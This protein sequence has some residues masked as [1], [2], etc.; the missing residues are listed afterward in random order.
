MARGTMSNEKQESQT[1]DPEIP[2]GK[3]ASIIYHYCSTEAFASIV[4][5]KQLWLSNSYA[6]S[7]YSENTWIVPQLRNKLAELR[8]GTTAAYLDEMAQ[9]YDLNNVAPYIASFSANGD[10]LSQW[11]A[12]SNDGTGVA[13]GFNSAAFNVKFRLPMPAAILDLCIGLAPVLY[14]IEQQKAQVT[15]AIEQNLQLY[16]NKQV[17]QANAMIASVSLLT[18]LSHKPLTEVGL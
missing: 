7:D 10:L 17:D 16:L 9:L 14:D 13:I 11:R 18:C 1:R 4:Q 12:Y 6:L 2:V 8:S 5:S 3:R 15:R